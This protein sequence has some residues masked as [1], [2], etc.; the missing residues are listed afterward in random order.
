M[1]SRFTHGAESRYA[2]IE[3]EA[4]AVVDALD[5]ARHFTLGCSDLLVAVDHKPLLK[6]LGDRALDDIANPR[7]RNIKEK[8]LRYRFRVIH[9]PGVRNTVA[10]A[11]SRHPVGEA[12]TPD[13][14]DDVAATKHLTEPPTC[15]PNEILAGL[16]SRD[17]PVPPRCS[18]TCASTAM[19][20]IKSVTW[21][22]VRSATASDRAMCDLVD[23]IHNGFPDMPSAMPGETRMYHQYRDKLTEFDGVILYKDRIVIPPSLRSS[24]LRA[25]HSAHQGI[26]MMVSRAEGSFFWPDMTPAIGHA[27]QRATAWRRPSQTCHLHRHYEQS[28]HSRR[29]VLTTSVTAATTILSS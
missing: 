25:L 20:L 1:G 22:D 23:A 24:V 18:Q 7:L 29:Y 26:S 3:G 9:I 5:K 28:T 14:P 11:L 17:D 27:V 13:V 21:D 4:L 12:E 8:S 10:D 6:V 15:P 2:P 19:E 16:R